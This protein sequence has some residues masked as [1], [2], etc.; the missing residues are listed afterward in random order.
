MFE[1]AAVVE[2]V[3]P[4]Q[5]CVFHG[6]ETAPRAAS[7]IR[8]GRSCLRQHTTPSLAKSGPA[9]TEGCESAIWAARKMRNPHA[10]PAVRQPRQALGIIAVYPFGG[11]TVPRTVS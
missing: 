2:P 9:S 3:H 1:Q 11:K 10:F 8:R 5:G 6:L 7:A 4:F